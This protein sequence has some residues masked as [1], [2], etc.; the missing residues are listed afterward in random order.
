MPPSSN[1]I[2]PKLGLTMTEGTISE[3]LLAPGDSFG[4]GDVVLVVETEKIANE[5]EAPAE[6]RLRDILVPAGETVEVGTAIAKWDIGE[7]APDIV[8][9]EQ[10]A[11]ATSG[12]GPE[13][14]EKMP[15]AVS[16]AA[17]ISAEEKQPDISGRVI[18]TP[19]AR[20]I[21]RQNGVELRGLDGS[22][23]KGRI[24]AADV[25]AAIAKREEGAI[26][27]QDKTGAPAASLSRAPTAYETVA[28]RRLVE[29]KRDIPH[30][31]LSTEVDAGEL[32]ALRAELNAEGEMLR[33][34]INDL[35][36]A[37][38]AR[39]LRDNRRANSVWRENEIIELQA[40]DIGLA[41]NTDNGLFAPVLRNLGD[42]GIASVA[43]QARSLAEKARDGALSAEDLVGGATTVSNAGMFD[44]TYMSSIINPGQSSI[45]GVG[46]IR[47]AFRPDEEGK[48]VLKQEMGLVLSCDHRI[49]DGVSALA[50][51]NSIKGYLEKPLRLLVN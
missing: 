49:L 5:I 1:L 39:A 2:M 37:A 36:I 10:A 50:F 35:I 11:P 29:S 26:L 14:M 34:S 17:A 24:K 42:A 27:R 22:G 47:Q 13:A 16:G 33:I 48:P 40:E 4:K 8:P 20:R 51:L 30:F 19:L 18:A 15:S 43:K 7:A 31:Y 46:S 25:Q 6:G 32:L 23:P 45:L 28:A 9:A 21:A 44:V 12:D 3:W 38:V 41:V